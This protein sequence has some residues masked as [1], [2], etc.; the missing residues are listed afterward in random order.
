M[1]DTTASELFRRLDRELWVVTAGS[2]GRRGGGLIATFVNQASL[3]AE[4]PRVLVGLAKHHHTWGLVEDSGAFAL[5]L[6]GE[7]RLEWVWRFGL[8]SGH[9]GD[10][11]AGLEWS[12]GR[13]G[14]PLLVGALGWLEC[15]VEAKLD[16]GDRTVYLAEVVASQ[17]PGPEAPLTTRRMLELAPAEKRRIL[18]EQ[19]AR[20]SAIDAT[21][22]E[23]WR[24]VRRNSEN[25]P[26]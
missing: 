13:T 20:D 19:V 5:H 23:D 1:S 21:A 26:A 8:T 24:R 11:L 14:T 9:D 2:A 3:V 12:E 25:R 6:L 15:Q 18:Q 7:E 16:T 17:L 10:K 4:L 22:I